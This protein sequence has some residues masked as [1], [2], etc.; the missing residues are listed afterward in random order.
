MAELQLNKLGVTP[1]Q[2]FWSGYLSV[3]AGYDDNVTLDVESGVD[4]SKADDGFLELMAFGTGQLS[5][6]RENG[7]QIKASGY[8]LKY[9]DLDEYDFTT[10]QI[11]PE[12]D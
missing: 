8:T 5:G 11:N 1:K 12:V 9:L 10:F 4:S 6:T 3:G 2:P 7:L